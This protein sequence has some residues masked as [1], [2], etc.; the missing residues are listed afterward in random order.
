MQSG[1]TTAANYLVRKYGYKKVA[2]ATPIKDIITNL[3]SMTN[4]EIMKVFIEPYYKLTGANRRIFKSILNVV[5]DM[6]HEFPK[7]RKRMQYLGTEGVRRNIDNEFWL[8]VFSNKY[9]S[10]EKLVVDD[11]RFMDEYL[12]FMGLGYRDLKI[13]VDEPKR[14]NRVVELHGGPFDESVL[15]HPSE[16]EQDKIIEQFPDNIIENNGSWEE[17][18]SSIDEWMNRTNNGN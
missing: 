11:C 12:Y 4:V 10:D 5:R 2:L 8:K 13:I 14:Y 1:K 6:P 7:P 17:Y 16:L 3:D 15:Q 9:K 18:Y